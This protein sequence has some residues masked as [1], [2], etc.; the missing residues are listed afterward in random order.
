MVEPTS[1][2]SGPFAVL[3]E[4]T[5]RRLDR[6]AVELHRVEDQYTG[7]VEDRS[8]LAFVEAL[9]LVTHAARQ[10]V[11]EREETFSGLLPGARSSAYSSLGS[12]VVAIENQL[13]AHL[14]ELGLERPKELEVFAVPFARLA[15]RIVRNVE[16]LFFSWP[17]DVYHTE[18]YSSETLGKVDIRL[19]ESLL[20][21]FGGN[22][23]FVKL[24]HPAMRERDIFHNAVFAHELGHIAIHTKV[25][26]GLLEAEDKPPGEDEIPTYATVSYDMLSPPAGL[27]DP[28][29]ES[30][31]SWFQEL[32]CDAFAMR[33]VGPAFA[34]AFAEVTSP[35]RPF[36]PTQSSPGEHPPSHIRFA[37]LREEIARFFPAGSKERECFNAYTESYRRDGGGGATETEIPGAEEWLGRVLK[38]FRHYLPH[39]L[40]EA[41][42]TPEMLNGDLDLVRRLS[43]R[44]TPPAERIVALDSPPSHEER[45]TAGEWSRPIDW[46]SILNGVL[47]WHLTQF[48]PPK[49]GEGTGGGE[50]GGNGSGRAE[51]RRLAVKLAVGGI[52]LSEFHIRSTYLREHYAHMRIHESELE[53]RVTR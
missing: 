26:V 37:F 41:E 17:N 36:E 21:L 24:W 23:T 14:P 25:P 52:E 2:P 34:I 29:R 28:Q 5:L 11:L 19:G 12:D 27:S 48:D 47:I 35:N 38:K 42:Y 22:V 49:V 18:N 10:L 6:I 31:L 51:H 44:G 33:F 40:G 32:A 9:K 20:N 43:Q 39:L 45:P 50:V 7:G 16:L 3:I 8:Y 15:R 13:D 1:D 46:R 4:D 30:L 53:K